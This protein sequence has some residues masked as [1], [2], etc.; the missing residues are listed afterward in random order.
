MPSNHEDFPS[1][2]CTKAVKLERASPEY[3]SSNLPPS[4]VF[5]LCSL[6][7][8]CPRLCWGIPGR[9]LNLRVT[10]L[11]GVAGRAG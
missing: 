2:Y 10:V 11:V 6:G 9:P 8:P 3:E 5:Y 4:F 1:E 7:L